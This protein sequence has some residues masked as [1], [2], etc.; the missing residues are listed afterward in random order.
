MLRFRTIPWILGTFAI[1]LA[2]ASAAPDSPSQLA[3]EPS[4]G[5][6]LTLDRGDE[7]PGVPRTDFVCMSKSEFGELFIDLQNDVPVEPFDMYCLAECTGEWA[8][9]GLV[10][11]A[12]P[13]T[14]EEIL[15]EIPYA[16]PLKWCQYMATKAC[17][18]LGP[19]HG[20]AES[21]F[22]SRL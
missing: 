1:T 10:P 12:G 11:V 6:S 22:G 8:R 19:G 4:T 17:K 15:K 14:P 5:L 20:L 21:C 3:S 13:I 16:D 18:K 2:N 7:S 9:P